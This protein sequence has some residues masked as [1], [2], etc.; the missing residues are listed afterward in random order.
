MNDKVKSDGGSSD[1]YKIEIPKHIVKD[2][3]DCYQIE[4]GD[5][6][7]YAFDDNFAIGNIIKALKRLGK[8]EGTCVE[9][10]VNKIK[11]FLDDY[12]NAY[13]SEPNKPE[14]KTGG[15]IEHDGQGFPKD[16]PSKAEIEV[17][18]ANGMCD[19]GFAEAWDV[20]W[21][22]GYITRYRLL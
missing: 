6:I 7:R 21:N 15:W 14:P 11:Y 19:I 4:T 10:D 12:V 2:L 17:Q 22:A 1:Y 13:Y 8:K 18:Y 9:Y 20:S 3:G 16:L 5:V